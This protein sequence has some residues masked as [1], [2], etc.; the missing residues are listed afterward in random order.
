MKARFGNS[1]IKDLG[2]LGGGTI[3][4]TNQ[5]EVT[6]LRLDISELKSQL[7]KLTDSHREVQV[8]KGRTQILRDAICSSETRVSA[9][10][11]RA[12]WEEPSQRVASEVG[13]A[14]Q[15]SAPTKLSRLEIRERYT[16]VTDLGADG[17]RYIE[18][19]VDSVPDSHREEPDIQQMF[20]GQG[21]TDPANH[22]S[23]SPDKL[24]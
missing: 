20:D 22:R 5:A 14:S 11:A 13:K 23:A 16:V 19:W 1:R 12:S 3:P 6:A 18:F 7:L 24:R 15:V 9:M 21:T 2:A 17:N 4:T 10:S 8:S